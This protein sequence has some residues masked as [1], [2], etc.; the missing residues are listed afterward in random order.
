MNIL[1][2]SE[3]EID[4]HLTKTIQE[5]LWQPTGNNEIKELPS[6]IGKILQINVD[7]K[8]PVTNALNTAAQEVM[9]LLNERKNRGIQTYLSN[10]RPTEATEYSLGGYINVNRPQTNYPLYRQEGQ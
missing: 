10:L 3:I 9:K 2:K 8:K 5:S 1:L 6:V 4:E 7:C